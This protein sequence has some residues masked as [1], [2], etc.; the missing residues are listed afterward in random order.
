MDALLHLSPPRL[1]HLAPGCALQESRWQ[2][3]ADQPA[4]H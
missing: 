3:A 2:L 1:S 4:A